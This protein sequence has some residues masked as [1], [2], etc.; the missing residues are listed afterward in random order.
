MVAEVR[1]H[2]D[3]VVAC[4]ELKAVDVRRSQAE[5]A[6]SGVE[7]DVVAAVVLLELARDVQSAVRA[8]VVNDDDFPV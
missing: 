1:V 6:R 5:F 8:A 3:D 7:Q 4:C 2:D